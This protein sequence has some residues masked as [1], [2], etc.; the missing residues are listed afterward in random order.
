MPCLLAAIFLLTLRIMALSARLAACGRT[1]WTP[2]AVTVNIPS[3]LVINFA[4][5]H[6]VA[7]ERDFT[8]GTLENATNFI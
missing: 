4:L 7:L 2:A 8:I 1:W 6:V 5:R 3:A